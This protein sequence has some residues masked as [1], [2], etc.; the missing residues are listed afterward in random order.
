MPRFLANG[1][2]VTSLTLAGQLLVSI[3]AAYALARLEFPGKRLLFSLVLAALVFPRYIAAVPSFLIIS[4]LKLIDTYAGLVLPFVGTPFAIFLL[5]QYFLQIPGEFFDA[6]NID[7]CTLAQMLLRVLMPLIRPAIGAFAIFSVVAH[8]NDFFWPLVVTR[9]S[10]MFTPPAGI[11]YFADAEAG[12]KWSIIMAAAIVIITPL[13]AAFLFG[14]RQFIES[15]TH[16]A[17]K[18]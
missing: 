11:V 9:S 13:V 2:V 3:P 4:R 7:G 16:T 1:V 8:W 17:I 14:R 15:M 18:G 6:A 10:R 12:T 5:R